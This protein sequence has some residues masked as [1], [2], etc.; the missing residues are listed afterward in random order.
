MF[1]PSAELMFY[2]VIAMFICQIFSLSFYLPRK[3]SNYRKAVFDSHPE[4][5][6]PKLYFQPAE[7]E[8]RRLTIRQKLDRAI[9]ILSVLILLGCLV[10][11]Q[12]TEQIALALFLV[13]VLQLLPFLLSRYWGLKNSALKSQMPPPAI[14]KTLLGARRLT[15]LVSSRCLIVSFIA[16]L[17]STLL[18]VLQFKEILPTEAETSRSSL[19]LLGLLIINIATITYLM[20]LIFK[21]LNDKSDD[22]YT[23]YP[24][25]LRQIGKKIRVLV[26]SSFLYS[27]FIIMMLSIAHYGLGKIPVILLTSLYIQT[28]LFLRVDPKME[29]D[30]SVYR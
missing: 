24:D 6:Y 3:W 5:E 9:G 17:T 23:A 22:L 13:L 12:P 1:E 18:A 26:Y 11:K 20:I 4:S 25:R 15:D 7:I 19:A 21:T 16:F 27:L 2:P 30:Y 28:I 8:Y 29:S 14:R 10:L